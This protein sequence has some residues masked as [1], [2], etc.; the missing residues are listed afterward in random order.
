MLQF[1]LPFQIKKQ[2]LVGRYYSLCHFGIQLLYFE[3]MEISNEEGKLKENKP[4]EE[5]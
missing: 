3:F 1:L 4:D 5:E 2:A